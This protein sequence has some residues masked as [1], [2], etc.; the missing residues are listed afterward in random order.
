MRGCPFVLIACLTLVACNGADEDIRANVALLSQREGALAMA[1]A[2]HLAGIG[3]RAI[4]AIESA[5]H[6]ATP[7]GRKN[8]VMALRKI[9]DADAVPLLGHLAA[10]DPSPDVAREAEWTL[11]RWAADGKAPA[12]AAGAHQALRAV[13]EARKAEGAG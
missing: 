7:R 8:L 4:P 5:L 1:A 9:G 13:E 6:T 3:R 11:R 2:D 12:R 10:Y